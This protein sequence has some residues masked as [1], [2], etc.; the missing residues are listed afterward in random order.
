MKKG[1]LF[2]M[3]AMVFTANSQAN[4]YQYFVHLEKTTNDQVPVELIC[5]PIKST[6]VTFSFPK[7][8]PGTYSIID[9]GRFIKHFKAFDKTG[10][11]LE[12]FLQN[13]NDFKIKN[14]SALYKIS[15]WVDDTYDEFK[16]TNPI[17]EPA[18]TNI[19]KD[20]NYI[21]NL[22]GFLGYFEN[23][24]N[25]PF[26]LN[27]THQPNLYGATSL[28]RVSNSLSDDKFEAKNYHELV[29]NPIMYFA[30]D[31]AHI[32]VE[33]M[34]VLVAVYSPSHRASA[35]VV[36]SAIDTLMQAAGKYLG[37][38]LPVDHYSFLIYLTPNMM[39]VTGG[40]GAL[41]HSYS[42]L[43]FLND[44]TSEQLGQSLY[45]I[46][47][48][49]FFHIITPLNIHSKE[50]G[51]FDYANPKMS[52]HLWLYEG[53]TEYHAHSVQVKYGL[54]SKAD[55]LKTIRSKME[56]DRLMYN[57]SVS[58]TEMSKG[59]LEKYKNEYPNVYAKGMLI[60]MCMDIEL[61]KLSKGKY[62]LQELI[63]DLAKTYGK[64]KSFDDKEL[65]AKIV[66]LTYPE[67]GVFFEKYVEGIEPLPFRSLLSEVGVIYEPLNEISGFSVGEI[68]LGYN[69]E[70]KKFVITDIKGLNNF[71][72]KMGYKPGD[73]LLSFNKVKINLM[74][75]RS[76]AEK[77][78]ATVKEGDK[79]S[80]IVNRM[81]NG[82][83]KKTKLSA[84]VFKDVIKKYNTIRFDENATAEKTALQKAWLEPRK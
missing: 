32:R 59:C 37:G 70:T 18:G 9:Y 40:L 39:G 58:F 79:L 24:I 25:Y 60:N 42:S 54:I 44:M 67:I 77:W 31:T 73:E 66:S 83:K 34:D 36:A 82:K 75:F 21:L 38:K 69:P 12:S 30:P 26:E 76:V 56:E 19:Q 33:N 45:D 16:I 74:N 22:Q 3:L 10:N 68:S 81:K 11:E 80:V 4:S 61:L 1:L 20:S 49:E 23:Q 84:I 7:T 46:A 50:I 71:G 52:E 29:D 35:K 53:S 47:S 14:A 78:K 41:E 64:E 72:K 48:H 5:P 6:E 2:G 62:G 8:V 51:D 65:K 57:D 13:E 27:I 17:F 28:H 63:T 15:Y 43:Y 55:F